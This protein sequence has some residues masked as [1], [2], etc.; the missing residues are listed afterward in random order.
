MVQH[1]ERKQKDRYTD[2]HMDTTKNITRF[3]K[4]GGKNLNAAFLTKWLQ[5]PNIMKRVDISKLPSGNRAEIE[6]VTKWLNYNVLNFNSATS[7][8]F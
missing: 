2:T 8:H 1:A 6:N 7:L 4:A 3:A 5:M